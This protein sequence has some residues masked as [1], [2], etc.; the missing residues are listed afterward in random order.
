[1]CDME[2]IKKQE[3]N[4]DII[5]DA[6]SL[7]RSIEPCKPLE[8][9]MERKTH[10]PAQKG[11]FLEEKRH[12]LAVEGESWNEEELKMRFLAHVFDLV[13]TNEP[14]KTKTFYG[15]PFTASIRNIKLSVVCDMLLATPL[16][17][18]TPKKPYFFPQEFRRAKNA[19]DAEGQMLVGMLIAQ[20]QNTHGKPICGCCLQGKNRVFTAPT[21]TEVLCEPPI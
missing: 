13:D 12:L 7:H 9:L 5:L 19:P 8:V 6:F 18:G 10:L 3:Y 15:R 1:M 14:G 21:R 17:I 11:A 20:Q 2:N 16:G 4:A